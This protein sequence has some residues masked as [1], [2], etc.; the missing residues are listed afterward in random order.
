G[1]DVKI[2]SAV[3]RDLLG[4]ELLRRIRAW[5][6]S[7]DTITLHHGLP[8]GYVRASLSATG[9]AT[10]D[11]TPSVAWDQIATNHDSLHA[12]MTARALCPPLARGR[13]AAAAGGLPAAAWAPGGGRA[14]R[15]RSVRAPPACRPPPGRGAGPGPA[16]GPVGEGS[17]GDNVTGVAGG[18]GS[19]VFG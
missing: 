2:V 7:T 4:D 19:R 3:G 14:L 10:Y 13:L 18:C 12:A 15:A 9:D 11:I 1:A 5:G 16:L 17:C 8:T 6:L